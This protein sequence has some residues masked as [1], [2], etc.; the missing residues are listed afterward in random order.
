V[1]AMTI[2]PSCLKLSAGEWVAFAEREYLGGLV[3]GGGSSIRFVSGEPATLDSVSVH[4]SR[5]AA[6]RGFEVRRLDAG[7]TGEDGKP[8]NLHTIDRL[9]F[10]VTRETD[11][12][13]WAEA[14]ARVFLANEGAVVPP[15][16]SLGD[17][18]AI[19]DHSGMEPIRLRQLCEQEVGRRI[20]D[21]R[22]TLEFRSAL[23][24]LFASTL[25]PDEA[26]PSTDQIL[27][28]WLQGISMG[29]GAAAL[30]KLQ[31]YG[32]IGP[33]NARHFLSSYCHWLRRRGRAGLCL[34]LDFRPYEQR[35][36]TA[37]ERA[38]AM[39]RH[40]ESASVRGAGLTLAQIDALLATHNAQP[41]VTYSDVAYTQMLASLRRFIDEIDR[42]P[43]LFMVV[44]SSPGFYSPPQTGLRTYHNYDALQT[45]IGQEF[46]DA[47][48]ANPASALVHLEGTIDD[49]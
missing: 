10:A 47:E 31:I 34:I 19:A 29:G 30:K 32:R 49:A 2:G 24:Y 45:R 42:F 36:A 16:A 3:G 17:L 23:A 4:L 46:A 9:F 6:E 21:H 39:Q 48:R 1:S 13:G 35:K 14:E 41:A 27:L 8:P 38:A 18:N 25:R 5:S 33:T 15:G 28:S 43:G 20:K 40:L 11:W 12:R 22:L 26:S 44:L 37:R 7:R